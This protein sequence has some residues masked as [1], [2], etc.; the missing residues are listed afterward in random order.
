MNQV[1]LEQG[2]LI[3]HN[4]NSCRVRG[5]HEYELG[6]IDEVT[7]ERLFL[8]IS[9]GY[10]TIPITTTNLMANGFYRSFSGV[11]SMSF[12]SGCIV[13]HTEGRRLIVTNRDER[14]REYRIDV[15]IDT[16]D[17]LQRALR[18]GR[19]YEIAN[20]WSVQKTLI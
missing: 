13:Y 20:S 6:L 5:L 4:G 16:V 3:L 18:Q 15:P 12:I 11:Y 1:I 9:N 8:D 19:Y 2:D 14:G 10:E 7:K 17:E